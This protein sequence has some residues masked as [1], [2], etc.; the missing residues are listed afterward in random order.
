MENSPFRQWVLKFTFL[1]LEKIK[2]YIL[3]RGKVVVQDRI[4]RPWLLFNW[5]FKFTSAASA[6]VRQKNRLDDYTREK[7]RIREAMIES[8]DDLGRKCLLDFMIEIKRKHPDF[9]EKDIINEACTFMLAVR[10]NYFNFFCF[11]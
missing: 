2:F 4:F 7:I 3:H 6:E 8:G 9:T 5:I 10:R 11:I 1:I